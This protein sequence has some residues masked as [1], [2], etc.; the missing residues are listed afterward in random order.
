MI[1]IDNYKYK[2]ITNVTSWPRTSPLQQKPTQNRIVYRQL[3]GFSFDTVENKNIMFSWLILSRCG[4]GSITGTTMVKHRIPTSRESWGK[5]AGS[6]S[7]DRAQTEWFNSIITS[8]KLLLSKN[9]TQVSPLFSCHLKYDLAL[10]VSGIWWWSC[11]YLTLR[12]PSGCCWWKLL[13][14]RPKFRTWWY[15]FT[16][17]RR[18]TLGKNLGV[19]KLKLVQLTRERLGHNHLPA[20][21]DLFHCWPGNSADWIAFCT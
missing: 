3:C 9:P 5:V 18:G 19:W 17:A 4:H 10:L 14:P 12:T 13:L 2:H 16:T 6:Y 8:F 15:E 21:I 1:I 11:R 7:K 20:K